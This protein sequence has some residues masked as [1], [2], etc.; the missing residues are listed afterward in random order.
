MQ[1]AK[2]RGSLE[3]HKKG[4]SSPAVEMGVERVII[5]HTGLNHKVRKVPQKIEFSTLAKLLHQSQG[6][7]LKKIGTQ[8]QNSDAWVDASKNLE[9]S[10]FTWTLW[11]GKSS[12]LFPF[13]G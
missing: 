9:S 6:P 13:K 5:R 2:P 12:T 8:S 10:D 1:S 4:L 11:A 3:L 7:H